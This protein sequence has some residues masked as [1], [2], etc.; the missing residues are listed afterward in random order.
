MSRATNSFEH[1]RAA[2]ESADANV[3]AE[4][5]RAAVKTQLAVL[6]DALDGSVAAIDVEKALSELHFHHPPTAVLNE[7]EIALSKMVKEVVLAG[8]A[9]LKAAM[10]LIDPVTVGELPA[11]LVECH[12]HNSM[13]A[14]MT[15]STPTS[16]TEGERGQGDGRGGVRAGV[17]WS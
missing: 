8:N 1:L 13:C 2:T 12:A 7:V 4:E 5:L 3:K 17:L 10:T 16:S 15:A 6:S 9:P 11:L 14:V